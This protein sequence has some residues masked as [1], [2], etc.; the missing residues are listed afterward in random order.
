M[1]YLALL[2][3]LFTLPLQA[4]TLKI[5]TLAPDG[6]YWMQALRDAASQI[7][8]QSQGRLQL[9]F[10]PGGVMGNDQS[11]LRKMRIGQLHGAVLTAGGIAQV[12]PESQAY[13]LPFLFRD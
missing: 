3:L 5:A 7:K 10:Y 8:Q 6:S 11:V 12:A 13:S 1:R 9:R 4:A 2:I